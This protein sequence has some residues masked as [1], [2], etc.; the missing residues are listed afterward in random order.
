MG[1][2]RTYSVNERFFD[3]IHTEAQAYWLG[4]L[5]A[6]GYVTDRHVRVRLQSTDKEHLRKLVQALES[7][8]PISEGTDRGYSYV[9][10]IIGS[11]YM[12]GALEKLG[13]TRNKSLTVQQSL[14]VP[15]PL[16]SHYWRGIF[17][18]DGSFTSYTHP[19]RKSEKWSLSL[20]GNK[21]IVS[22]FSA[23]IYQELG[24]KGVF[25]VAGNIHIITYCGITSPQRISHMLYKD[26]TI[27]LKRKYNQYL[28]LSVREL[29]RKNHDHITVTEVSELYERHQ[30]WNQVAA[31]LGIHPSNLRK[32]R[33]LWGV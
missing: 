12:V 5:T 22:S 16:L 24:I 25:R 10:C 29:H 6:D 28:I 11:K 32:K 7:C 27:C 31:E 8:H 19:N 23:F 33:K 26:A 1:R 3:E 2:T 14:Q 4:F 13:V 15:P 18:G 30:N 9:D 21:Y 20:A 17:D